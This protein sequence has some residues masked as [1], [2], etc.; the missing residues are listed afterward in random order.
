MEIID[1]GKV[2][3]S[4]LDEVKDYIEFIEE[5]YSES[6]NL[7][8]IQV[9]GDAASDVYVRNKLK[10]CEQVGIDCQ[11]VKLPND[12]EPWSLLETIEAN[13]KDDNVTGLML[14]LP[15]PE[16]LG[17]PQF[18]LDRIP[19]YKDVDG[20]SRASIGRL[21][22]D[23]PNCIRP[24][25]AQGIMWLLP[26]DMSGMTVCV[27]GRS[28]LVG[29]PLYKL[30]SDRNATV[31]ACHSHTDNIY[32]YMEHSDIIISAI[33]KP[34]FIKYNSKLD[35]KMFIDVG[36]NRDENGKLCGDIDIDTFKDSSCKITP[37]PKGVGILTTV[38]L[39][40]NVAD[41]NALFALGK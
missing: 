33:G 13:A 5:K 35:G 27:L 39:A 3:E 37:V 21:W 34:K 2:R 38:Q 10:T 12:C 15:L 23:H 14:Q 24:A 18:Y 32:K 40:L 9:E 1:C 20:L 28:N 19:Y 16:T 29:K 8:V 7:V 6:C 30:L 4:M 22:S 36:I 17:D 31:I 25:T 26:H 11:V 41:A